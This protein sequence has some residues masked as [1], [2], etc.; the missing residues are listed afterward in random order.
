MSGAPSAITG[1]SSC[2]SVAYTDLWPLADGLASQWCNG[3][4]VASFNP[5]FVGAGPEP[6]RLASNSLFNDFS[7]SGREIGA[8]G[9]GP[10]P[11]TAGVGDPATV[12]GRVIVSP[13]PSREGRVWVRF[14]TASGGDVALETY[15]LFGRRVAV[16]TLTGLTSGEHA[17]RMEHRLSKGIYWLRVRGPDLQ[18]T[19]RLVVVD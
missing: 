17:I 4:Q 13:N 10:G 16:E 7:V 11:G 9:P 6:Y 1:A 5:S 8:Y 15:D 19:R 14:S 18:S 12:A 3:G 2:V